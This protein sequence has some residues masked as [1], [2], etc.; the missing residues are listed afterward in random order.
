MQPWSKFSRFVC[1]PGFDWRLHRSLRFALVRPPPFFSD[2]LSPPFLLYLPQA[3]DTGETTPVYNFDVGTKMAALSPGG[4][5]NL[6]IVQYELSKRAA[7]IDGYWEGATFVVVEVQRKLERRGNPEV[8]RVVASA[9]ATALIW[10]SAKLTDCLHVCLRSKQAQIRRT[11]R[12][13]MSLPGLLLR[14]HAVLGKQ[15]REC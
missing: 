9:P 13:T 1:P 11:T 3:A 15:K 12:G 10:S 8:I 14:P 5:I 4:E 6:H 7:A 2:P